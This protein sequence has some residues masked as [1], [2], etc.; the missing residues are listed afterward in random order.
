MTLNQATKAYDPAS[1][2]DSSM[3]FTTGILSNTIAGAVNDS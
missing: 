3:N 1:I 2:N